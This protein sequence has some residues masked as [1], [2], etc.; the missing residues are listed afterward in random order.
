[1]YE[2][3][4]DSYTFSDFNS[5]D[6]FMVSNETSNVFEIFSNFNEDLIITVT[7]TEGFKIFSSNTMSLRQFY[8]VENVTCASASRKLNKIIYGDKKGRVVFCLLNLSKNQ[9]MDVSGSK[10]LYTHE[11]YVK[12]VNISPGG[13]K[14][15]SFGYLDLA[16]IVYDLKS[17]NISSKLKLDL[18]ISS[19]CFD[20]NANKSLMS[21]ES[22]NEL[23]VWDHSAPVHRRK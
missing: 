18:V 17:L 14:A 3:I 23:T 16:F 9:P 10:W 1:M 6:K 19:Y 21:F 5:K 7:I 13:N 8:E 20:F 22:S 12:M 15:C 4:T 11:G 2:R